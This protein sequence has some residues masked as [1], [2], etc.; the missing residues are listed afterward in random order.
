MP[1]ATKDKKGAVGPLKYVAGTARTLVVTVVDPARKKAGVSGVT[2]EVL[3]LSLKTTGADG[4]A[5]FKD[6]PVAGEGESAKEWIVR[7][8]KAG[9]GPPPPDGLPW[10][11][12]Q[13][14]RKPTPTSEPVC[15]VEVE[16]TRPL[17]DVSVRAAD[18]KTQKS[19]AGAKVE[20]LPLRHKANAPRP[21]DGVYRTGTT[22]AD[23]KV[24]W[25]DVLLTLPDGT[26][27]FA[28]VARVTKEGHGVYT[29]GRWAPG[30][31][32][33]TIHLEPTASSYA[34]TVTLYADDGLTPTGIDII[35]G[36]QAGVPGVPGRIGEGKAAVTDPTPWR[37][38]AAAV[39]SRDEHEQQQADMASGEEAR[40]R[41]KVYLC[42]TPPVRLEVKAIDLAWGQG[43]LPISW[44]VEAHPRSPVGDSPPAIVSH[45]YVAEVHTDRPGIWT[46]VAE[47]AG[48]KRRWNVCF[49]K[50]T[51]Q[52][53]PAETFARRARHEFVK[54]VAGPFAGHQVLFYAS[55]DFKVSETPWLVR[56]TATLS[57]GR[58]Q[59]HD[60]VSLGPIQ[61]GVSNSCV[62]EY[63]DGKL[64]GAKT[65]K[66][67]ESLPPQNV[68]ILDTGVSAPEVFACGPKMFQVSAG[69]KY[70]FLD[71]PAFAMPLYHPNI[72]LAR[73]TRL[74]GEMG[75]RLGVAGYSKDSPGAALVYATMRWGLRLR[76]G[77]ADGPLGPIVVD[78]GSSTWSDPGL[79]ALSA[80]VD[81]LAAGFKLHPPRF[82]D[83]AQAVVYSFT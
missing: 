51:I 45:G 39:A 73:L 80:P 77:L 30:F 48:R 68:P 58:D 72:P 1:P 61:N 4:K 11:E 35:R 83:T 32:L 67:V 74:D 20:L 14:E 55:G 3:G 15:A 57:G 52:G 8:R 31:V 44:T 29:G 17:V 65:G 46:V 28:L 70:Q 25:K 18:A 50:V 47:H 60:L 75:F 36:R 23:G 81:P 26:A 19:L 10:R 34:A 42:G 38:G 49:V 37:E 7:V 21:E 5:T 40:G 69:R 13:V 59:E 56:W 24:A 66:V 76:C 79:T 64:I 6:L 12:W 41:P 53:S 9:Y 54:H 43:Y 33:Q 16:L 63:S 2:V 71:A 82:I 27:P 22:G 62:A 78:T